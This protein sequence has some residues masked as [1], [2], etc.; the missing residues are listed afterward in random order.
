MAPGLPAPAALRRPRSQHNLLSQSL[1]SPAGLFELELDSSRAK[2]AAAGPAAGGGCF[3]GKWSDLA[4]NLQTGPRVASVSGAAGAQHKLLI[5]S[6]G[7]S[8]FAC[9]VRLWHR[10]AAGGN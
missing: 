9:K 1:F 5:L 8:P 3:E 4:L 10:S 7:N 6:C 2:Q